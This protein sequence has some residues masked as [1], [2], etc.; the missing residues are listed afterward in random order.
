VKTTGCR[1]KAAILEELAGKALAV[2]GPM[3]D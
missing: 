3:D 2:H 1:W